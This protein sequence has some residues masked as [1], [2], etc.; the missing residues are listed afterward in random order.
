LNAATT[1]ASAPAD[2]RV[3]LE[4]RCGEPVHDARG[5]YVGR[6]A[7]DPKHAF[8]CIAARRYPRRLNRFFRRSFSLSARVDARPPTADKYDAHG[9]PFL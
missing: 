3:R 5:E 8:G 9:R 4:P 2:A 6:C 7:L 1:P